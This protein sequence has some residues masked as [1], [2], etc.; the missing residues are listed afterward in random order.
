MNCNRPL[1]IIPQKGRILN[2]S[3]GLH[4]FFGKQPRRLVC[5]RL[6]P[7]KFV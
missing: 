3:P 5:R 2:N 6:L 7:G 4:E 1:L